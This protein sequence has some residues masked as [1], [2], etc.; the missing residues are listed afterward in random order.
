MNDQ[1]KPKTYTKAPEPIAEIF[2][3]NMQQSS[4]FVETPENL[5]I[6]H[7]QDVIEAEVMH[8]EKASEKAQ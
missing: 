4:H 8:S 2:G 7:G 5:P 3:M 1:T 6:A